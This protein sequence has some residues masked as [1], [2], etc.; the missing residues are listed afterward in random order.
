MTVLTASVPDAATEEIIEHIRRVGGS[1]SVDEET[2]PNRPLPLPP[3]KQFSPREEAEMARIIMRGGDP[4][5]SV[6]LA[7]WYEEERE[8]ERNQSRPGYE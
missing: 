7:R 6:E 5:G 3:L 1:V 2:P 4:V 8:R